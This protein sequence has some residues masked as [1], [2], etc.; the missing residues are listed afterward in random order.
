[1][2]QL[3]AIV[4]IIGPPTARDLASFKRD[5][6][7]EITGRQTTPLANVLPRHT[8]REIRDLLTAIFGYDPTKRP[9]ARAILEH[10]CFDELFKENVKMPNGRR[11][12]FTK[13][14]MT[15]A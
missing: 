1:M 8:P 11:I 10:A 4:K 15:G 2:G 12:P 9:T 14:T 5:E 6:G 13:R 3:E 7:I